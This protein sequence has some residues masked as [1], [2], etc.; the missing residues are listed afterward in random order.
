MAVRTP[1]SLTV[2]EGRGSTMRTPHDAVIFDMDGVVTDTASLHAAAWKLM[3]DEVLADPRAGVAGRL[4]PFDAV[5]DYRRYVDGR[6]RE[7]GVAAFL[8]SRGIEMD[9]GDPGDP[10]GTWTVYGLAARKNEIFLD[11][12]SSEGVRIFPGTAALVQRLKAAGTPLGLVTASLNAEAMLNAAGLQT[13]FDVVVD[14]NVIA[15]L[16]LP[17]KPD[18]ATFLQAARRLGVSPQRAAVIE[19]AV[20]GV[21]A[22]KR[23]GFGLVVGIDRARQR[24]DLERAGADFVLDDVSELDLGVSRSDP[25]RLVYD[26]YDPVH[27]THREALTALGNGYLATRGAMPEHV[28]DGVHY[29][30]VYLAGVYNRLVSTVGGEE[31]VDEE[32]INAPNWLPLDL[33]VEDG[34]WWSEEGLTEL[35][36]RRELDLRRGLLTR[37]LRL[38]DG[39]GRTLHVTQRRIVSMDRAHVCALETTLRPEGWSGRVKAVSGIDTAVVNGNAVESRLLANRHLA[40]VAVEIAGETVL[41]EVETTQSKVRVATAL[42]TRVTG[43]VAVSRVDTAA[44]TR[45][46]A[47]AVT[48]V[49]G[50]PTS[51]RALDAA[52][53][54]EF[55][56]TDGRPVVV[57][58]ICA[59]V[60]SRDD[61]V[62]S[63]RDGALTELERTDHGFD[64]L[65]GPHE[66]AW[67]RLWKHYAVDVDTD[68]PVQLQ[69]NLHVFHALQ[70]I[71]PN[72]SALDAGVPA[73]GLHGEGYRGHVFWDELF[74]LPLYLMRTPEIARSLLDY[75]WR[76]LEAARQAAKEIG[77]R[78]AMFPWQSGSDGRDETPRQ[79][80]NPRSQRWI[81]DNS[82]R[83]RHVGLAVAYNAWQYFQATSD[84]SWF[85]TR[86]AEM[87]VEVARFFASLA[88]YDP[89]DGRFHISGV[90][91]PD[92]YHDGYPDSPGA[93]LRDN[94]YTNVLTAWVC[95]R[96][97]ETMSLLP[98]HERE[99]LA[100]HVGL[101]PEEVAHWQRLAGS[102]AIP[103]HDG[104]ISQFDGYG[105]LL[106][107]DWDGY[108]RRYGNIERLDLILEAEGDAP[109]RYRLS[110]QA[111]LLMLIYLLGP[112]ELLQ[113]L[114]GLGYSLAV[115]DLARAVDYYL[116]RSAHGSTLS[117]VVHTSVLAMLDRSSAWSEFREAL[118]A[119]LD[120][121][122]G[123]TTGHGIHLGAMAGT[124]DIVLRTFTGMHMER[125]LLAFRPRPPGALRAVGFEVRYRDLWIRIHLDCARLR[126]TAA[127]GPGAPVRVEVDG[128]GDLLAAGQSLE[129][130]VRGDPAR[131]SLAVGG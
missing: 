100:E 5:E 122:Q 118:D 41:A 44:A 71:S 16:G 102:L 106:E 79:L 108:R 33:A 124:V 52:L 53:Q 121:T 63:P 104:L 57:E 64:E 92:E 128:V 77:H 11:L 1:E 90:M 60:T 93:G 55:E 85:A 126:L 74:V 50:L 27:E 114:S 107:F 23:G 89:R 59:I 29:P 109:H 2:R 15:A 98:P 28:D 69:L 56:V 6:V 31:R 3:F 43:A 68:D 26:G 117:R 110:K 19:D 99:E 24:E 86:G 120:D 75:R 101:E 48:S 88:E 17:G 47:A 129:F 76:R 67:R 73:R 49:V 130:A 82:W 51:G 20:S 30:G 81:P 96:A 94:A 46:P 25:W 131:S 125:D 80:F 66:R 10:P 35:D 70:A 78:G 13:A 123:G 72:T 61:A 105:D 38:V 113:V 7:D 115:E 12:T 91:G 97:V 111:D 54:F 36:E 22:A 103:F 119:D 9:V 4:G 112:A 18:P 34:G 32:L 37:T 21:T 39:R 58:K 65:L 42:R 127:P 40:E 83:Q 14:G 87:I 8:E 116:A 95:R 84:M 62:S 45:E